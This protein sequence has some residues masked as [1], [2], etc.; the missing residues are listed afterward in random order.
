MKDSR[1]TSIQNMVQRYR[2]DPLL[3]LGAAIR[4]V[5]VG[6]EYADIQPGLD[7]SFDCNEHF[8]FD[9]GIYGMVVAGDL[10]E[11]LS[12]PILFLGEV[13]RILRA[14]GVAVLSTPNADRG[15]SHGHPDHNQFYTVATLT[16]ILHRVGFRIRELRGCQMS[17]RY[18]PGF[19]EDGFPSLCHYIIVVVEK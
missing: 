4:K 12:R 18:S 19:V 6:G 8:P 1:L 3:E 17:S 11:H 10:I 13:K 9:N 7:Y 14:G 15:R 2:Q 16:T 5:T